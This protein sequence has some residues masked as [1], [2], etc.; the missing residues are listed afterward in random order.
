MNWIKKIFEKKESETHVD[1]VTLSFKEEIEQNIIPR[2]WQM[3]ENEKEHL[4]WLIDN[5][6]P[7]EMI[8]TSRQYLNH[9]KQRHQEYIDYVADWKRYR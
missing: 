6:A 8:E 9:F 5:N 3:A 2:I 1:S 4:N 7:S